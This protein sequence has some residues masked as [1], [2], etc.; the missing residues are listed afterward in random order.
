MPRITGHMA[1]ICGGLDISACTVRA[2]RQKND[3]W[4]GRI[5]TGL[6]SIVY[7]RANGAPL[8]A[9]VPLGIVCASLI[10]L[11]DYVLRKKDPFLLAWEAEMKAK[12][13][14]K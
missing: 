3:L 11:G 5:G 13:E 8:R 4:N 6:W 1:V 14:K 2:L 12:I 7:C 9:A 10:N